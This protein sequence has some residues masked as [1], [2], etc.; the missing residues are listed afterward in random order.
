[1]GREDLNSVDVGVARRIEIAN[2]TDFHKANRRILK[3]LPAP[4]AALNV[5]RP[6]LLEADGDGSEARNVD[7][8]LRELA[9]D[10]VLHVGEDSKVEPVN[11]DYRLVNDTKFNSLVLRL[12]F[13]VTCLIKQE[14]ILSTIF[15]S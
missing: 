6:D 9:G 5:D 7:L 8:V 10:Q 4:D 3:N 11:G 2:L 13:Y 15:S 12:N 1:M 14:G